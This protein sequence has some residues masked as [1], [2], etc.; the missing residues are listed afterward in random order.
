M[1]PVPS[2]LSPLPSVGGLERT[3]VEKGGRNKNPNKI[4]PKKYTNKQ[5]LGYLSLCNSVPF[6]FQGL[7]V[8]VGLPVLYNSFL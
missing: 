5:S 3:W 1:P 8:T 7:P 6:L 2:N 4:A